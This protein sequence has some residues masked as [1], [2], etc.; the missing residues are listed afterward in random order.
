M[1][2]HNTGGMSIG[3]ARTNKSYSQT[4]VSALIRPLKEIRCSAPAM[5]KKLCGDRNRKDV[6]PDDI[7]PEAVQRVVREG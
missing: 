3:N 6:R 1:S 5:W 4:S 2:D 7:A